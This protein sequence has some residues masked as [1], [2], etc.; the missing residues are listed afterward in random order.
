[1]SQIATRLNSEDFHPPKRTTR[2]TKGILCRFLR[3]REVRSRQGVQSEP[4][5]QCLKPNEWW[6]PDL[7]GQLSMPIATLH[8]WRRV[9][10]V[11]ARKLDEPRGR[12]AV[13]AD[14]DELGRLH[15]LRDARHQHPGPYPAELVN[16][17]SNDD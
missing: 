13:Y 12:W 1:L 14:A 2:F 5:P 17:R 10:W 7:A 3:E 4:D 8:R 15:R 11:R 16:P 6:L 9:G